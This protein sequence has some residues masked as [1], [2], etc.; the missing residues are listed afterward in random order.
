M[1][2]AS[3][4]QVTAA[5]GGTALPPSF[6]PRIVRVTRP[7][8]DV[9]PPEG[10]TRIRLAR[11]DAFTSEIDAWTRPEEAEVCPE[12]PTAGTCIA[13]TRDD[14]SQIAQSGGTFLHRVFGLRIAR[15]ATRIAEW[16][17][18]GAQSLSWKIP[19]RAAGPDVRRE[20]VFYDD[21]GEQIAAVDG[22]AWTAGSDG[23]ATVERPPH[24]AIASITVRTPIAGKFEAGLP[25]MPIELRD[26]E[27]AVLPSNL[28]RR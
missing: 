22:T 13:L 3:L 21:T 1:P 27:T 4:E 26:G 6:P 9:K 16:T 28:A 24:D 7:R 17:Q 5:F 12:P 2:A 25:P 11:G 20:I 10:W 23:V 18:R 15:I 14:F 8:P 19:V